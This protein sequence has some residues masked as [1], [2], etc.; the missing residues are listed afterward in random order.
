MLTTRRAAAGSTS[1]SHLGAGSR[2]RSNRVREYDN[3][4][5]T[6]AGEDFFIALRQK[7]KRT[8]TEQKFLDLETLPNGSKR[9]RYDYAIKTLGVLL[10]YQENFPEDNKDLVEGWMSEVATGKK[11]N[12][13]D[14]NTQVY[15]GDKGHKSLK[16]LKQNIR[17]GKLPQSSATGAGANAGEQPL[18]DDGF[19]RMAGSVAV[20]QPISGV[21][22][23]DQMSAIEQQAAARA[24][25]AA[26][27]IEQRTSPVLALALYPE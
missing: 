26:A 21:P 7:D 16:D 11:T 1:S 22:L 18:L 15:T 23:A 12:L 17:E 2:V 4:F 9:Q 6:Q 27:W 10:K 25:A 14:A 19:S 5:D 24:E 20:V 3:K 13:I 8:D